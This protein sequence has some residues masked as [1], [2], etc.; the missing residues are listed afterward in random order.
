M[1]TTGMADFRRMSKEQMDEAVPLVIT[2]DGEPTFVLTKPD[3][4]VVVEDLH[5]RVRNMLRALEKR[6]RAGMAPSEKIFYYPP[7][8]PVENTNV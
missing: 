6:A 3:G 5:P 8:N 1:K 2:Y 4:V 7:A